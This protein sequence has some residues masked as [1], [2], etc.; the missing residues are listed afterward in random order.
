[1][2]TQTNILEASMIQKWLQERYKGYENGI[3]LESK[4]IFNE[5]QDLVGMSSL[6]TN[7]CGKI[8]KPLGSL[9]SPEACE[10]GIRALR[11]LNHRICEVLLA[12]LG[13]RAIHSPRS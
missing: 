5:V 3:G 1:M 2:P 9:R 13:C 4:Q 6:G 10:R 7:V 8:Y 11:A 12:G